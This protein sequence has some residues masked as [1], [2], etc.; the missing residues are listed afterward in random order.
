[1][2]GQQLAVLFQDGRH[3]LLGGLV[4]RRDAR[5][6]CLVIGGIVLAIVGSRAVSVSRIISA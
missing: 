1:M 4:Q 3:G 5:S 2:I 6:E